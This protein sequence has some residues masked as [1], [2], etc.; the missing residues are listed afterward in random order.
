MNV[1]RI[2]KTSTLLTIL[3]GI[4]ALS[5]CNTWKGVGKDVEKTGEAM[6]DK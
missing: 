2:I 1:R 4:F 6:Q 5:G 3:V